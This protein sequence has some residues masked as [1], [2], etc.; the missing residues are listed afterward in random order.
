MLKT[1][2]Y[3]L[4]NNSFSKLS[5]HEIITLESNFGVTSTAN[6]FLN[7]NV[8]RVLLFR[9][10][11]FTASSPSIVAYNVI[12]NIT[13]NSKGIGI[14]LEQSPNIVVQNN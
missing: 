3:L 4:S 6:K 11:Q 14:F 12:S 2:T 10:N 7:S 1:G 13:G 9:A 8:A 5:S